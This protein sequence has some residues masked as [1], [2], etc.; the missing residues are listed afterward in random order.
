MEKIILI[1]GAS[2]DIGMSFIKENS[3][4]YDKIIAHYNHKSEYFE[5]LLNTYSNKILGIKADFSKESE[6]NSFVQKLKEMQ[7]IPTHILHLTSLPAHRERFHK[8]SVDEYQTMMQVSL[9]SIIEILKFCVP[10]MQKQKYG[11]ILFLLSAYTL[12]PDPKFVASYVVTKYALLGLMKSIAAEYASKGIIANGI[13]PQM[14][15][16]KFIENIP[17]LL[18]EQ[19]RAMSPLGRLVQKEDVLPLMKLLLSDEATSI[20][21]ENISVSG[22]NYSL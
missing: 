1:T 9:Y 20:T 15:E 21:G 3:E 13:S 4:S 12:I 17:E 16:T 11:K 18:I 22:G 5:N 6:V 7:T 8:I 2:S 19:H 14:M 10:L